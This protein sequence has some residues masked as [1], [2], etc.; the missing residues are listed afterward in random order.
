M[1]INNMKNDSRNRTVF[2]MF[3]IARRILKNE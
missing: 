3:D 1:I 2:Y